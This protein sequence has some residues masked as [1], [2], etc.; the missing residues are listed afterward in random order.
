M[1]TAWGS[2]AARSISPNSLLPTPY[3]LFQSYNLSIKACQ[4]QGGLKS[5]PGVLSPEI[6]YNALD[7]WLNF[8]N[9]F[10][11]DIPDD[12][13]IH[14]II[15]MNDAI[16]HASHTLPRYLRISYPKTVW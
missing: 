6:F 10:L 3:S 14:V 7:S 5:E 2:W 16:T 8:R 12:L 15:P 13:I 11:D 1:I 4:T 9:I